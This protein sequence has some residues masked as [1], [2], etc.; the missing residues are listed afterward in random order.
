MSKKGDNPPTP[1]MDNMA[2]ALISSKIQ[3]P[4][5]ITAQHTVAPVMSEQFLIRFQSRADSMNAEK[6]LKGLRVGERPA[7]TVKRTGD[8]IFTGC[9]IFDEINA[10]AMLSMEG[11]G[12]LSPFFDIFYEA[13]SL[14]SGMHHPDGIL[15]IRTPRRSHEVHSEK[16]SLRSIAPTILSMLAVPQP[17]YM[18]ELPLPGFSLNPIGRAIQ[19]SSESRNGGYQRSSS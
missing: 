8:E 5:N 19:G 17:E 12:G 18:K 1:S 3:H 16:V 15:W 10:T 13:D 7:L 9:C 14:K 11:V 6:R 4:V 2:V